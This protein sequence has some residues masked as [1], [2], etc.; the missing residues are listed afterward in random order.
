MSPLCG[1]VITALYLAQPRVNSL[2]NLLQQPFHSANDLQIVASI[3]SGKI[4]AFN[5]SAAFLQNL[6]DAAL[7]THLPLP[8]NWYPAVVLQLARMQR[9]DGA[10]PDSMK[11]RQFFRMPRL[12]SSKT[13]Q[14][15]LNFDPSQKFQR[16]RALALRNLDAEIANT[17]SNWDLPRAFSFLP[18]H[19]VP[20]RAT[21][22][23]LRRLEASAR[24]GGFLDREIAWLRTT[25]RSADHCQQARMLADATVK[26]QLDHLRRTQGRYL[27]VT[28]IAPEALVDR[29]LLDPFF[30]GALRLQLGPLAQSPLAWCIY[31]VSFIPQDV[32]LIPRVHFFELGLGVTHAVSE[33]VLQGAADLYDFSDSSDG[34]KK[35]PITVR[36]FSPTLM[37]GALRLFYYPH[38]QQFEYGFQE[39]APSPDEP[40]I[41]QVGL[42]LENTLWNG[43]VPAQPIPPFNYTEHDYHYHAPDRQ[44]TPVT[45]EAIAAVV[46][47]AVQLLPLRYRNLPCTHSLDTMALEREGNVSTNHSLF[48]SQLWLPIHFYFVADFL[49]DPLRAKVLHYHNS[50]WGPSRSWSAVV[51]Q[52]NK[53]GINLERADPK[54]LKR[55]AHF[56]RAMIRAL[57]ESAHTAVERGL[58]DP[59]LKDLAEL[60]QCLN[61]T[62]KNQITVRPT[63]FRRAYATIRRTRSS[64]A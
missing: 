51:N 22:H 38:F 64:A 53:E 37:E 14:R 4:R 45:I 49:G 47:R 11:W 19:Q 32:P 20:G 3:S 12:F 2:L 54:Q 39:Y 43:F 10:G 25:V 56:V 5:R 63:P 16:D 18:L 28:A 6:A 21:P 33:I 31:E 59:V 13:L 48:F 29:Y 9:L 24:R 1:K 62:D 27:T 15:L 50:V 8:K 41:E 44:I 61:R 7:K 46:R 60:E 42:T 30:L 52:L 35:T 57:K 55:Y 26:M 34:L 23:L 40:G 17:R 58:I 36:Y